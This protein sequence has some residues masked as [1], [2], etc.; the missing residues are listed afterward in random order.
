MAFPGKA[1]ERKFPI[2]R[3]LISTN[4]VVVVVAGR[5]AHFGEIV[6]IMVRGQHSSS[7]KKRCLLFLLLHKAF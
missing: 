3:L 6:K 2:L 1:V 4:I 5:I 7:M